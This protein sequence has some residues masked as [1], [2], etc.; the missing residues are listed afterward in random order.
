MEPTKKLGIWC[1]VVA[2]T[3]ALTVQAQPA[4][5][6]KV[7]APDDVNVVNTPTVNANQN[8]PWTVGL[9]GPVSVG[10]VV[11]TQP[12]Q[13]TCVSS[14]TFKDDINSCDITVPDGKRLVVQTISIHA[15]VDVGVR[16]AQ[17]DVHTN[18]VDGSEPV[19]WMNVPVTGTLTSESFS[20]VTQDVHLYVDGGQHHFLRFEVLYNNA[21][22]QNE[23]QATAVGYLVNVP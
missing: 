11:P 4:D 12:Y 20:Q 21:T 19:L 5:A 17:A 22:V 16:V 10:D 18:N 23:L 8:G 2:A 6:D 9:S 14:L 7:K 15:G 3:V 1:L 13:A